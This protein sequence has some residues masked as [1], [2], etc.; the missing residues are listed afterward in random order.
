MPT[1]LRNSNNKQ[2]SIINIRAN[3]KDRDLIN[4]AASLKKQNRSEF[5]IDVALREAQ[6]VILEQA[7]FAIDANSF[8]EVKNLLENPP[9]I[10]QK[11]QKLL[12]QKPL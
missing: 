2:D 7:F 10:N 11:L 3:S 4:Y 12:T 5:M 6:N 8:S 9:P 1:A